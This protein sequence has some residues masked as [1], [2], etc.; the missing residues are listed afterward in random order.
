MMHRVGEHWAIMLT[1]LFTVF[2]QLVMRWQVGNA[3]TWPPFWT[4]RLGF[5]VDLLLRPW[6]LVAIV[7]SFLAG[8]SWMVAMTRFEVSYAFP[9][10]GL[11]FVLVMLASVLLFGESLTTYK[12]L[13][14]L[15]IVMGITVLAWGS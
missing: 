1:V 12:V 11:N 8:V 14:T 13:G 7:A 15:L 3:G 10:M 2:S 4:D 9:F 5:V 6:V